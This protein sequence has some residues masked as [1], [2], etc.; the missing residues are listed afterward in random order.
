M[1]RTFPGICF[2]A[3]IGFVVAACAPGAPDPV[4][5][6][7]VSAEEIGAVAA[8]RVALAHQSVGGNL[9]DGVAAIATKS[10]VPLDITE[11]REPPV[12]GGGI[13]HF[14]VGENGDPEGK[15]QDFLGVLAMQDWSGFDI[16][17]IK[18][19][20]A[21]FTSGTDPVALASRYIGTVEAL[22][23]RQPQTLFVAVTAPLTTV[24]DGP[25][26]WVKRLLGRT[27]LGVPEN[28]RRH[29]FNEILRARF[30]S[31]NLFD[32][33]KLEATG[34]ASTE[35]DGEVVAVLNPQLSSDG[36]H[37]NELGKELL[38]ASFLKF[39]AHVR[40]PQADT[41]R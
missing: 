37:L 20:Y 3:A 33:A 23:S 21:D 14:L 34:A 1:P 5:L 35:L 40:S 25:R 4:A 18:L 31:R 39:V 22:Q 27:P 2:L 7:E 26:A 6:P 11:T 29:Q 8:R 12:T 10:G 13:F 38:G 28:A 36:G 17:M 24:Q 15:L 30:T 41:S 16:A 19:C 32:L 9:L